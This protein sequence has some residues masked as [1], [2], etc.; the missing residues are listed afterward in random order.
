MTT[1][2]ERSTTITCLVR[3]GKLCH[4]VR[5]LIE[6]W[7]SEAAALAFRLNAIEMMGFV[8]NATERPATSFVNASEWWL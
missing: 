4:R 5:P 2:A 1:R 7:E 8:V 3:W 6:R